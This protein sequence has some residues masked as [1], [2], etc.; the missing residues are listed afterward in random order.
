MKQPTM[1]KMSTWGAA[2]LALLVT[3]TPGAKGQ[4]WETFV[5]NGSG[6]PYLSIVADAAGN[7][8]AGGYDSGPSGPQSGLVFGTTTGDE[9][10]W[11][12]SDDSNPDLAGGETAFITGLAFDS[13]SN[14]W[15]AG[16]LD[17]SEHSAYWY[18]RMSSSPTSGTN[19]WSTMD[20]F[21]YPAGNFSTA[22][23]VAGDSIGNVY[24]AGWGTAGA[25]PA[26]QHWLVRKG[27]F[28]SADHTWSWTT[29][30]DMEGDSYPTGIAFVPPGRN[31]PDGALLVVGY[32]YGPNGEIALAR[33]SLDGGATWETINP[34]PPN[35][36]FS[37][38][39]AAASDASGDIYV[40][41]AIQIPGTS[42][43]NPPEEWLVRESLDGGTTWQT[44][45]TYAD[46]GELSIAESVGFDAAGNPV[47]VGRSDGS[48]GRFHWVVRRPINGTWTNVD[49]YSAQG[50][51]SDAEAWGVTSDAAGNLLVT[52]YTGLFPR[53]A[54]WLVR[55]LA[56]PL[57]QAPSIAYKW[58]GS[59]HSLSLSIPT[60]AGASYALEST[61]SLS[62]A[63]WTS[64]STLAG[65]G[66][67]KAFPALSLTNQQGFY[68]VRIQ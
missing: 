1:R 53:S 10:N 62:P 22:V 68:R 35:A 59:D 63:Q 29:V 11:Y 15:S 25:L 6:G 47:V 7:V 67:T 43:P 56:A 8:F 42:G 34:F 64:L 60:T 26:V 4:T 48:D 32:T 28:S 54:R 21:Q 3:L 12:L 30:D 61:P 46:V 18:V 16:E 24:V 27:T 57:G 66:T 40:A 33:R 44:I 50:T 23:S 52:G 55:R 20:T 39:T 37:V 17:P 9:T 41:G 5:L 2:L 13:N 14:L 36:G 65:D 58:N 31:L 45:D 51:G 38:A 49:Y 19:S